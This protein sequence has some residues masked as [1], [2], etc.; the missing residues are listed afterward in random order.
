MAESNIIQ[1]QSNHPIYDAPFV[2]LEGTLVSRI[3]DIYFSRPIGDARFYIELCHKLRTASPEDT[4]VFYLNTPGGNLDSGIQIIHAIRDCPGKVIT[5]LDGS[6]CSMGAIIFLTGHEY[7]VHDTARMMLHNYSGGIGGKGNELVSS[8]ESNNKLY[9]QV[10]M[11]ICVPFLSID[12]VE[13]LFKGVDFWLDSR[14]VRDRLSKL[15]LLTSSK[16]IENET[17]PKTKNKS[18][19]TEIKTKTKNKP[20]V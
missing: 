7:I 11:D 5:V 4:F 14:E 8:L 18:I 20:K 9:Q 2:M 6:V 15:P 16:T 17:K 10:M 13:E 19:K 12:E 3:Y 1:H